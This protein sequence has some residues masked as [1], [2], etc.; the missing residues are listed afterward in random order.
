MQVYTQSDDPLQRTIIAD[1]SVQLKDVY[2]QGTIMV[3]VKPLYGIAEAGAYWWSTY[4]KHHIEKLQMRT[5]TFD[6]CPL[7]STATGSG[8]GIVGIQTDDTLAEKKQYLNS[9]SQIDFN[10]CVLM[11]DN[12][13]T[14]ALRQ[15]Q[16]CVKLDIAQNQN[17]YI[18]QRARG[19]CIATICQ[20][21]ASFDLATVAQAGEPSK[22]EISR[23]NKR[24][25]WQKENL[26]CGLNYVQLNMEKLKL[27]TLVDA[28]FPN[29]KDMSLQIT[30][31]STIRGNIVHWS[32]T[33]CKR[34]TRSVLASEIY[35][36]AHGFDIAIAIG[37]TIDIMTERLNLPKTP[38]V[39]Y[40]MALR[41]AYK[42][43]KLKDI[44]ALR[45][46]YKRGKLKDIRWIDGRGNLA[47]AMTKS[48]PNSAIA[49][50][51]D[52]NKLT[53]RVQGWVNRTETKIQVT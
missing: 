36:M 53:L 17:S 44:M 1:L 13:N 43:G 48:T 47:D 30:K 26:D 41:E 23:L 39:I 5:S 45:E 9:S 50:L 4:F 24:I 29:N 32:S 10:G 49:T 8:F 12:T 14:I 11:I 6:P 3:V 21:E 20:P 19:A 2:P 27:F 16:Q 33:K 42:R 22:E 38:I 34:V 25:I 18:K 37:S 40:I 35:A 28:S 7:I 31:S 15:K 51:I 46:A 52:T